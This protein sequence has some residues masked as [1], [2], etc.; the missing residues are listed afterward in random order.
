MILAAQLILCA[1][2]AM[3]IHEG[4]HYAAALRFG[5]RL[6]FT[7]TWGR[8]WKIPVPRYVWDMPEMERMQQVHVALAGFVTEFASVLPC[9]MLFPEI[10]PWYL[11]AVLAHFALYP[12]YAGEDNDWKWV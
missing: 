3:I 7:F 8:L 5:R 12:L 9:I 6:K 11:G 1:I 2:A 10:W 4:G